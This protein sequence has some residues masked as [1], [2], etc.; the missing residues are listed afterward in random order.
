VTLYN[1]YKDQG[2]EIL[3]FPSNQFGGQE[4]GTPADI[5]SFVD[6][7]GVTFPMMSKVD[8]NGD[9]T[10]PV[11]RFLKDGSNGGDIIWNFATKFLVDKEGKTLRRFDGM[12]APD[13]LEPDIVEALNA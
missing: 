9:G 2:L 10:S 11:Y 8:V 13:D 3:A 1:K 4:P 7:Y 6:K 5:R 12:K